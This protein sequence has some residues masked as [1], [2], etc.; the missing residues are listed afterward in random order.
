MKIL[1]ATGIYPPRA[2]GPSYFAQGLKEALQKLG[3]KVVV[4]TFTLERYL[5]TG[6]RHLVYFLKTVPVYLWADTTIVMDTFSV[7]VPVALMR[8]WFGK[9]MIIRTGGDFLW[10]QYVQRSKKKVLFPEFYSGHRYFTKKE[11]T[12][13]RL[14]RWALALADHV[15]FNSDYQR[16]VWS[17]PYTLSA[18]KTSIIENAFNSDIGQP[19]TPIRKNFICITRQIQLKNIEF[20]REAFAVAKEKNPEIFLDVYFDIP[21]DMAMKKLAESYCAILVS[22]SDIAPNFALEALSLSKP[23]ILTKETGLTE[24]IGHAALYVDPLSVA[25]IADAI[26]QMAND[27]IYDTYKQR[28]KGFLHKRT[29]VDIARE[30]VDCITTQGVNADL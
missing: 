30:F 17:G 4:R 18:E 11:Q 3:H 28:I 7:A 5:P 2:G 8:K 10:E 9:R 27:T 26:V 13:F 29:Y 21:H 6:L 23:I 19:N 25:D 15:V 22:I 20:L 14:T 1:I 12:I 16:R 24:R